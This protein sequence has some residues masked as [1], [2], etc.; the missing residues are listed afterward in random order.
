MPR[1]ILSASESFPPQTSV[2]RCGTRKGVGSRR[3]KACQFVSLAE[4]FHR[5]AKLVVLAPDTRRHKRFGPGDAEAAALDRATRRGGL[6]GQARTF[7]PAVAELSTIACLSAPVRAGAFLC[8]SLC[9]AASCGAGVRMQEL[10]GSL[11]PNL[12]GRRITG[13]TLP[14]GGLTV[15]S[16]T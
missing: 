2:D 4:F 16:G 9:R 15:C 1:V 13:P 7:P 8:A 14:R 5:I 10:N 3:A 11:V 12:R 6:G